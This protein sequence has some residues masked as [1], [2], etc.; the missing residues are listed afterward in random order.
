MSIKKQLEKLAAESA[1]PCVSISF[2]THRTFPD[3][4]QDDIV[5]KKL[6]KEAETSVTEE[7]GKRPVADLLEKIATVS[8]SIDSNYNL[9]SL[10]IYLSNETQEIIKSLLPVPENTVSVSDAFALRPIMK[11]YVRNKEYLILLLTQG[12]VQLFYA[13]N[14]SANSEIANE[15]FPYAAMSRTSLEPEQL[16]DAKLVDDGVREYFNKVDKAVVNVHHQTEL[17]CVVVCTEDNYSRLLQVADIPSLYLGHAAVDYNNVA[18]HQ[19][20][21]QAWAIVNELE[22]QKR[23]KAIE[24]VQAAVG[25][26]KVLTDLQEIYQA[27]IDGRGDLLI[28]HEDFKQAVMMTGDRTFD[29]VSDNS[30]P[31]SIDD[32][33]SNIGWEVLSKKGRVVFT[34]QDKIKDLGNIVLKTRY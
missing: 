12:G 5:L 4:A 34:A 18:P 19:L 10:H 24:E 8:E 2:N 13:I 30:L 6:L 23:T 31:H 21:A 16:S 27:A 11:E 20:G 26:G 9:N 15:D 33:T 14:E 7:F 25:Q 3:N 17:Q 22:Q 29:L 28:V 32:I 1:T